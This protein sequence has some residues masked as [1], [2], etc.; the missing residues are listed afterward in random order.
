CR[1]RRAAADVPRP[2]RGVAENDRGEPAGIVEIDLAPTLG[3]V[4]RD[5]HL[6]VGDDEY[7]LLV[8]GLHVEAGDNAG[9]AALVGRLDGE[10]VLAAHEQ[11]GDVVALDRA[12]FA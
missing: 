8:G 6:L 10:H 5:L 9:R 1:G 2:D 7:F 12:P 3:R 4:L 11:L